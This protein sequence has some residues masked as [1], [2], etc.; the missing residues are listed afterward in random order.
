M[1]TKEKKKAV[2]ADSGV[3]VGRSG[4]RGMGWDETMDEV[5]D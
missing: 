2:I 1:K 4:A 5:L 3:M